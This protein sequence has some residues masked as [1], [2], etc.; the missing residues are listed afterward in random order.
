M[1][2][3]LRRGIADPETPVWLPELTTVLAD[4]GWATLSEAFG[5]DG[6]NYGTNRVLCRCA[7][8]PRRVGFAISKR[9]GSGVRESEIIVEEL[10][11]TSWWTIAK[12]AEPLT[13][14]ELNGP[15]VRQILGDAFAAINAVSSLHSSVFSIVR[16]LHLLR[17]DS[18]D[19]YDISFSEPYLPFSIFVSVPH[20]RCADDFLRVAEGIIHEAMH[21]QLT[22]MEKEIFLIHGE[23]K[24]F[25][26]PWREEF[27]SVYGIVH[28]LYVFGVL[29]Q[30][31]G[32]LIQDRTFEEHREFV[33][34]RYA[35]IG[36]QISEVTGLD[37]EDALTEVGHAIINR[38]GSL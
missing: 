23:P 4:R 8:V 35:T 21:L 26:S 15:T 10:P 25:Y 7:S 20:K 31:Y 22:L 2:S 34:D 17:S 32:C 12:D 27:R 24:Q 13:L 33:T 18:L 3:E 38:I 5:I 1:E 19:E 14:D 28:G 29:R 36:E 37:Y 9:D 16:S 6:A 11:A 30:Y